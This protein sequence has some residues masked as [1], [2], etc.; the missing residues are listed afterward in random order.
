MSR[1][2]RRHAFTDDALGD[3]DATGVAAAI[4]AGDISSAEAVAA[5]IARAEAVNPHLNAVQ[6]PDYERATAFA[7]SPGTGVFA[8]VPTVIKDNTDVA[9]LASNQGSLA[10]N[11]TP[12]K[13]NAAVTDQYL[14]TGLISLGKS[15]MPEF[16]FNASTEYEDLPPTRN[17]WDTEFSAGASSGGSAALVAAGVVPIAHAND[18]GGSIR[19]P[20]AACGLVGLKMTRGRELPDAHAKD[21][22]VNL[23]SNGALTRSVRDTAHFAAQIERYRPAPSLRPIG[24]VEG[25]SPKRL[26]IG[27]VNRSLSEFPVDEATRAAVAE[28]ARRLADLGHDVREIGLPLPERDL[29]RFKDDFIHLWG[30]LAFGVQKFGSRVMSPDFD[31]DRTESLT[32]GLSSQFLRN[33]WRT[34]T[35]LWRLRA[36]EAKYHNSFADLDAMVSPVVAHTTPELGY[37]SPANGFDVLFPRLI[38]Y[39]AFTPL[40]NAAGGPAISLPLGRT[41]TGMP[42]GVQISADHGDER[43]LLELAWELEADRPFARIQDP[44]SEGA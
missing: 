39:V 10:V 12:A 33:A 19:I 44:V 13:R 2:H 29:T 31:G 25:P 38:A 35:A 17:P 42:L 21:M 20:A 14:S 16:G 4:A 18:G 28:T 26:R 41:A 8:G 27:V 9:G 5:A 24:L 22:P 7:R 36:A 37:L 30:L 34:P 43:T 6:T 40:N 23:V 32:R 1:S 3:L 15:T 11:A